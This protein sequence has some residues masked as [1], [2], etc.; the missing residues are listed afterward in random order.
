MEQQGKQRSFIAT[1]LEVDNADQAEVGDDE[2]EEE[3]DYFQNHDEYEY[4]SWVF[5]FFISLDS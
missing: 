1:D 5:F 2:E 4:V 3:E